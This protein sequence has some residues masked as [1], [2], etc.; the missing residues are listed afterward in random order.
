MDL[1]ETYC[2]LVGRAARATH[3]THHGKCA[4]TP[5]PDGRVGF[6]NAAIVAL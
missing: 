5:G 3:P 4:V 6:R 1:I 2:L